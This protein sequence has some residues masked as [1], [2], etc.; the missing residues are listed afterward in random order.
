MP[1]PPAILNEY[2]PS[3][4]S[5]TTTVRFSTMIRR[6]LPL[7]LVVSASA[8][9]AAPSRANGIT[10]AEE[11]DA[12]YLP[13]EEA[14]G[15]LRWPVRHDRKGGFIHLNGHALRTPKLRHLT[16]GTPLIKLADL[17]PIGAAVTRDVD[18]K[19]ANVED[20]DRHFTVHIPP[21]RV[22]VDLAKQQLRAWQGDRLVLRSRISSGR[23]GTT[24][25][26][27]FQ[28]GPYKEAVHYST[29]YRH[30]RMPWSVQITGHVFIHGF[31]SV[32]RTPASHGCVRLPLDEGNPAK[33]FYDWVDP[34]TPVTIGNQQ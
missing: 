7:V 14:A 11:P 6:L 33:F 8:G 24:P 13:L 1:T 23:D 10:F 34:G 3:H 18:A 9:H 27:S 26:G 5:P 30:A 2:P 17:E 28:A 16:D 20:N 21:K 12:V 29:R 31:K 22:E 15:H 32:P 19:L 25:T 4:R